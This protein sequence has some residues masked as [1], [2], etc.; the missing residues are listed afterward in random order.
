MQGESSEGFKWGSDLIWLMFLNVYFCQCFMCTSYVITQNIRKFTQWLRFN[1]NIFLFKFNLTDAGNK[2][3]SMETQVKVLPKERREIMM[4]WTRVIAVQ[5]MNWIN[6]RYIL[7]V[8]RAWFNDR[9]D[10][11]F[12]LYAAWGFLLSNC[13]MGIPFSELEKTWHGSKGLFLT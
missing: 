1:S 11:I 10:L 12:D 13:L 8:E 5:I 9:L 3:R 2:N 6:L 4:P 7:E